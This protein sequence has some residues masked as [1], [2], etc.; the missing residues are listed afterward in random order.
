MNLFRAD[1]L[2]SIHI[3][4]DGSSRQSS[5][6]DRMT[7]SIFVDDFCSWVA[8]MVFSLLGVCNVCMFVSGTIIGLCESQF[9]GNGV[10]WPAGENKF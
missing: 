3:L 8:M 10:F 9:C 1:F 6:M 4:E 7:S 2:I 5:R